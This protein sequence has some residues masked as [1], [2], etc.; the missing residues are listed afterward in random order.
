MCRMVFSQVKGSDGNQDNFSGESSTTIDNE[1]VGVGGALTIYD[2][3]TK[4]GTYFSFLDDNTN[5]GKPHVYVTVDRSPDDESLTLPVQ[6]SKRI[7]NFARDWSEDNDFDSSVNDNEYNQ[8]LNEIGFRSVK[9]S[10]SMALINNN[11]AFGGDLANPTSTAYS[12]DSFT[13]S[14]TPDDGDNYITF[15]GENAN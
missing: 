11:N 3:F 2:R 6:K 14:G 1:L 9:L 5:D 13:L 10:T 12:N 4:P 15:G 8:D 7:K